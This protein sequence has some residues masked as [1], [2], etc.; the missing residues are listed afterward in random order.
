MKKIAVPTDNKQFAQHFGRCPEYT[1]F[2][3][4]DGKIVKEEILPN[5]GHK[6]GFL[7]NFL[8]KQGVD[9]ILASGMKHRAKNIFAE[10]EIEVVIGLTGSVREGINSY[11]QGEVESGDNFCDH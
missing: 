8:K 6:P 5:P 9:C 7:P 2:E 1:I 4:E 3:I 11:L 10:N